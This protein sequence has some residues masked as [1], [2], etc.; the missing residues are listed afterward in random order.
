MAGMLPEEE[1]ADSHL[2]P[3]LAEG[4]LGRQGG[5]FMTPDE[6]RQRHA[7]H[8]FAGTHENYPGMLM[9][10]I[11]ARSLRDRVGQWGAE[12]K[13]ARDR[14]W[15]DSEAA[16][17]RRAAERAA[18]RAQAGEQSRA[19]LN[20]LLDIILRGKRPSRDP[21]TWNDRT[22]VE[23]EEYEKEQRRQ[24]SLRQHR[25]KAGFIGTRG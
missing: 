5:R 18:P 24:E 11:T 6:M 19:A 7:D 17:A 8:E 15:A 4:M 10:I 13:A 21:S 1:M 22:G 12:R 25:T 3:E 16:A 23:D 2:R 14:Y 9:D 20:H